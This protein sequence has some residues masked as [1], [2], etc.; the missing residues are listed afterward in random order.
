MSWWD[1]LSDDELA[2]RLQQKGMPEPVAK[3]WVLYRDTA[4]ASEYIDRILG[5]E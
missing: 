1:E 3:D 2:A 4:G 5:D